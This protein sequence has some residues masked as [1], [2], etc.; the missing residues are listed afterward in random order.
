[1]YECIVGTTSGDVGVRTSHTMSLWPPPAAFKSPLTERCLKLLEKYITIYWLAAC[2]DIRVQKLLAVE[3]LSG[4]SDTVRRQR[5]QGNVW[6]HARQSC[7]PRA[8]HWARSDRT[9]VRSP[10]L[11]CTIW[12]K[13]W[14]GQVNGDVFVFVHVCEWEAFLSTTYPLLGLLNK[15]NLAVTLFGFPFFPVTMRTSVVF[16]CFFFFY[17][18][19]QLPSFPPPVRGVCG[20]NF[21]WLKPGFQNNSCISFKK[22][23]HDSEGLF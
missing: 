23:G 8:W 2:A 6:V 15:L 19:Q 17:D 4:M 7:C 22:T 1:M 9:S 20:I 18:Y 21:I 3:I 5:V 11:D 10:E 12:S 16:F 13:W 14:M